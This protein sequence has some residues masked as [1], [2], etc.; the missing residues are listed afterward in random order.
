MTSTPK[1]EMSLNFDVGTAGIDPGST[2]DMTIGKSNL[3][4]TIG[5]GDT[6]SA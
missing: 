5:A 4:F 2:N 1:L 6:T 3:T